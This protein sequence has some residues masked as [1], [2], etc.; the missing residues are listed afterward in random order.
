[1]EFKPFLY[2]NILN[3]IYNFVTLKPNDFLQR[4]VGGVYDEQTGNI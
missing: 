4:I 2:K 3:L 1:M